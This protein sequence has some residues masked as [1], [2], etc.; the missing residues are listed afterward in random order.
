LPDATISDRVLHVL[1]VQNQA[2]IEQPGMIVQGTVVI[3][4]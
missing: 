3:T 4:P 1:A 2:G